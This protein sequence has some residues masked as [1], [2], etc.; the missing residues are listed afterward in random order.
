MGIQAVSSIQLRMPLKLERQG[1]ACKL[2]SVC[3]ITNPPEGGRHKVIH[4]YALMKLTHQSS[5]GEMKNSLKLDPIHHELEANAL[6]LNNSGASNILLSKV[7]FDCLVTDGNGN[8][9][10]DYVAFDLKIPGAIVDRE[11]V[12]SYDMVKTLYGSKENLYAALKHFYEG[13][14]AIA[15]PQNQKHGH[16][17]EYDHATSKHDQY[18]RHT[19]QLLVAYLALPEAALMLKNYLKTLIRGKY[20]GASNL[21]VYNMGLHMHSTKT[22]CAP[23]EYS[24]IG[25]MNDRQGIVQNGKMRSFLVNFARACSE[26]SGELKITQPQ[27]SPFRLLVT[28]TANEAD[29]HHKSQPR[30]L[31]IE[32][33]KKG[34][35]GLNYQSIPVKTAS[36]SMHIFQSMLNGGFDRSKIAAN[37]ILS[38]ITVGI[39]GSKSTSGSPGTITRVKKVREEEDT[40]L[41][42]KLKGI[43]FAG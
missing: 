1:C 29:A 26:E 21:K 43:N 36:S 23:C 15:N 6:T 30:Y 2:T 38:Q 34:Q 20:P 32:Y 10:R 31:S 42:E 40:Q 16:E 18:I 9:V 19:E 8:E 11:T 39:S 7:S 4:E 35:L 33:K 37:P 17:P 12:F 41:V 14:R 27:N 28:V 3:R 24:L 5:T 25:L 13:G 22:C